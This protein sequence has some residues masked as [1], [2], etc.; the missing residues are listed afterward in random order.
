[1][2]QIHKAPGWVMAGVLAVI[3]LSCI[4]GIML[5]MNLIT[6]ETITFSNE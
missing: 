5:M 1:M 2:K 4:P 6:P 3:L